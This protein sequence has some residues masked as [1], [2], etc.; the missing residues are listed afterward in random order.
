MN[1]GKESS[2]DGSMT[3]AQDVAGE[4]RL[5]L[6]ALW[7]DLYAELRTMAND[8]LA[9]ERKN[10]TLQPTALVHELDLRL[11]RHPPGLTAQY[12]ELIGIAARVM[13]Q[14]L[15]NYAKARQAVKRGSKHTRVSF[16][17]CF[18]DLQTRSVDLL[19]LDEALTDLKKLDDRLFR[20]V[21]LRFFGGLSTKA[22]AE[23]L[24]LSESAMKREWAMARAWL[25]QRLSGE[26]DEQRAEN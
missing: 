10:H 18:T 13:R 21:E 12:R 16:D 4:A 11:L 9:A 5:R 7:P 24:G 20:A 2:I 23:L 22:A 8:C 6:S 3:T 26:P 19:E 14:I 25:Y 15:V 1:I 17:E